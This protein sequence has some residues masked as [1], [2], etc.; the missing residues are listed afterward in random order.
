MTAPNIATAASILGKTAV[1]IPAPGPTAVI[2]AVAT[3][4]L[5]RVESCTAANVTSAPADVTVDH[6]RSST[7]TR[8]GYTLTVPPKTTLTLI[9]KDAPVYLEEGDALRVTSSVSSA[10]EIVASYV[11]IS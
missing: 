11:D 10:L 7:A 3:G 8:I 4:H 9:G 5:A 1:L 6:Y 2:S